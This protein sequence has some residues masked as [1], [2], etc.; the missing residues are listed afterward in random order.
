VQLV[1][2]SGELVV[3][4]AWDSAR[5]ELRRNERSHVQTARR[6]FT[7]LGPAFVKMGQVCLVEHRAW[8]PSTLTP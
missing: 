4:V 1:N 3:S 2:T 6:V 8:N 5:G 7:S